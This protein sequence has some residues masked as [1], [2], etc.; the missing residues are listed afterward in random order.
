MYLIKF[1][2]NKMI[3]S[4]IWCISSIGGVPLYTVLYISFVM[5]ELQST[6]T[7]VSAYQADGGQKDAI[8]DCVGSMVAYG[9]V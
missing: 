1:I 4:Y 8:L 7:Y 6:N 3:L 5:T 2:T 9:Y